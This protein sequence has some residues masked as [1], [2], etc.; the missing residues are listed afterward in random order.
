MDFTVIGDIFIDVLVK[1]T[2]S[3]IHLVHGGTCY[4]DLI[5]MNPGGSGNIAL[6]LSRLGCKTAFIGKSG[7]DFYGNF[8]KNYLT[9]ENVNT[10]ILFSVWD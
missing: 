5:Q 3:E 2:P 1:G 9:N 4:S 10:N 6:G 8:Y 7:N